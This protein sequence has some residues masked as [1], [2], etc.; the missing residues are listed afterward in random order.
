MGCQPVGMGSRLQEGDVMTDEQIGQ[1]MR[2]LRKRAGKKSAEMAEALGMS[3]P[4]YNQIENGRS[5]LKVTR[6]LAFCEI[7]GLHPVK[8]H[9]DVLPV[10]QEDIQRYVGSLMGPAMDTVEG[11]NKWAVQGREVLKSARSLK[12]A[13]D[14]VGA[15]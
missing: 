14:K 13:L 6:M 8:F 2:E 12:H 11:L 7:L 1:R 4:A 5:G 9:V 15:P 10:S 3:P